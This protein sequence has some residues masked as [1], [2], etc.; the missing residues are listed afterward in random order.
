[1]VT[2]EMENFCELL[3]S[4]EEAIVQQYIDE[5]LYEWLYKIVKME[6]N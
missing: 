6:N 1:M 3:N 2:Y 4:H 5:W